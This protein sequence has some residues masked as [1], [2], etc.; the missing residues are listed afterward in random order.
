[1]YTTAVAALLLPAL[2][3]AI[4]QYWGF[5]TACTTNTVYHTTSNADVTE[6]FGDHGWTNYDGN[7]CTAGSASESIILT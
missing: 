6:S 5:N 4:P 1:M 2:T 7:L 3:A